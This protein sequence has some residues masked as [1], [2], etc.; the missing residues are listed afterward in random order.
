MLSLTPTKL[1]DY[2][3]CPQLY[4]LRHIDRADD[5]G[6][7]AALSFGRSMHAALEELHKTGVGTLPDPEGLLRRHWKSGDYADRHESEVYFTRGREALSR[8]IGTQFAATGQILGTEVFMSY[9]VNMRGLRVKL[10]CKADRVAVDAGGMLEVLDYKT[11]ASGKLPTPESLVE[12]LPTFLYYVLT[13]IYYPE[14]KA[15]RISLLNVLTLAKVDVEY[16]GAKIEVN[17]KRLVALVR[18]F[19]ESVFDPVPSEA[20]VWCAVQDRCPKFNTEVDLD[21]L[22]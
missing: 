10:G 17:K 13:R 8:Y 22:L 1:R 18:V 14:Y 6:N 9:V 7:S 15:V 20:C 19:A 3:V 11:N 4:K 21:S 16:A 5:G 12:D 2:L